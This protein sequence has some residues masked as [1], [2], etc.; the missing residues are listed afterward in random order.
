MTFA[1][2]VRYSTCPTSAPRFRYASGATCAC[3]GGTIDAATLTSS[4]QQSPA[5]TGRRLFG[6]GR[7]RGREQPQRRGDEQY[8]LVGE[9]DRG[10]DRALDQLVGAPLERLGVEDLDGGHRAVGAA[11]AGHDEEARR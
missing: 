10:A 2:R 4:N 3:V 5:L 8:L 1:E 6:T 11:V 7:G 9:G